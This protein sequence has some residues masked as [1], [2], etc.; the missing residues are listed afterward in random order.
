VAPAL[1]SS[2]TLTSFTN[3]VK[4]QIRRGRARARRFWRERKRLA[5]LLIAGGLVATIAIGFAAYELLKRP[6]DIH[7]P[8][9]TFKPQKPKKPKART[10]NWP[11]FGLDRARTRYLPARGVKPPYKLIWH[12]TDK[13]LIEFPPV[14][15]QGRLYFVNNNGYA[16][17]LAAKTGKVLW[18]RRIGRLNASSPTYYRD[19]LYI[20]NLEP[21]HVIKLDAKTGRVL[22]RHSLP[23]RAESSPLVIGRTLYFG[24]E[25]GELFALSTRNGHVRWATTLG[26]AVKSAPA[27]LHGVLYVGDYG[28]Y[29]NAVDA[30]TGKIRWQTASLGQG[31]GT[32]GE[33]YST[34]AVAFGRVYAGN[35]DHRVYSFD[36]ATGQIAW[37]F[38]TGG[39]VYSGPAVAR[40]RHTGPTVYIGSF[41]GNVY[42]LNAKS[43]EPRWISPAGGS[44]IGSLSAV[45]NIV[46]AAEFTNGS[47]VGFAMKTGRQVFRYKTGTYTPVISDGRRIY[48]VGYSSIN[49]LQPY[50]YQA[51]VASRIKAHS[52]HRSASGKQKAAPK[53]G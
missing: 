4:R 8:S 13:P 9:V 27:F 36:A 31:F 18:E 17:A 40:T 37:S 51:A 29:M 7:N 45:G 46:Y 5:I 16:Y 49:A 1:R 43:G 14:Y 44:V 47:T 15:A 28:G 11:M 2:A 19:R 50:K 10:V 20:V 30:K 52:A 41:D 21:G 33:F 25:D 26:G 38:S 12:Y 39:Y 23:G 42:A 6:A 3:S 34:P 35:N 53:G 48:L 32:S 22:W 24:C